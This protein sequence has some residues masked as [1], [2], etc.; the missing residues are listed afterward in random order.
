M[1]FNKAP[2]LTLVRERPEIVAFVNMFLT[3]SATGDHYTTV[4]PYSFHVPGV[5]NPIVYLTD[6]EIC[7]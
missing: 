1:E 3:V 6:L 5:W 2:V 7:D 4:A